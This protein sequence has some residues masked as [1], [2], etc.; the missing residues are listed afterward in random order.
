MP[1]STVSFDVPINS[2]APVDNAGDDERGY[3]EL[4]CSNA[5]HG[6]HPTA[7][8]MKKPATKGGM[9]L[10][11]LRAGFA[12]RRLNNQHR[13]AVNPLGELDHVLRTFGLSLKCS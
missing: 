12:R 6:H 3:Q 5:E 8:R 4:W 7:P 2:D 9:R 13:F 11:S 10:Q 1:L